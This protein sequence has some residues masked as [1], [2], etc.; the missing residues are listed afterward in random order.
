MLIFNCR[1]KRLDEMFMNRFDSI[2][3][4]LKVDIAC[5]NTAV[6]MVSSGNYENSVTIA[7]DLMTHK[8][9]SSSL[10]CPAFLESL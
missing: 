5:G 3:G 2:P 7:F 9:K 6:R 1:V 10:V 8:Y 4:K